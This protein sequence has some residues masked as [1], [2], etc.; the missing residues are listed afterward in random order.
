MQ[1]KV[2]ALTLALLRIFTLSNYLFAGEMPAA[3]T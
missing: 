1:P 2:A 3:N